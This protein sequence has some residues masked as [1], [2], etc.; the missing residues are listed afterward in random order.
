[1]LGNSSVFNL[2]K[3][4]ENIGLSVSKQWRRDEERKA[5]NKHDEVPVNIPT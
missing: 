2:M 5:P 4:L 1:M 3:Y